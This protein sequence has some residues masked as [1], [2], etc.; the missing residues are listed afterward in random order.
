MHSR[1]PQSQAY[2]HFADRR[3]LLGL[4]NCFDVLS[5]A[6]FLVVGLVGL[7]FLFRSGASGAANAFTCRSERWPYVVFF[8][9]VTLTAFGSAYYHLAPDNWRL[10]WDRLPMA[11]GFMA[12]LAAMIAERISV[13]AGLRLL[14]PL[15]GIGLASVVYWE[16]SEQRG[17]GDLRLYGLVQFYPLVAIILLFALFPPRYTGGAKLLAV[18][19]LY[20]LAK[21][22]EWLDAQ[23]FAVTRVLSGHTLKHLCAGL[24]VYFILDMLEKRRATADS[25]SAPLR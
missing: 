21:V 17:A 13:K 7:R 6:V 11:V 23:V 14:T 25:A 2:H 8:L 12:F 19:G 4:P 18:A 3:A 16:W 22:F 15:V 5:N 24:A 20:G 10:L 1:I 9:G